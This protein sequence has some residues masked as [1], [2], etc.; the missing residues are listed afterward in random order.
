MTGSKGSTN[1]FLRKNKPWSLLYAVIMCDCAAFGSRGALGALGT[2]GPL[3]FL[4]LRFLPVSA[5]QNS[6]CNS[7]SSEKYIPSSF[8][9]LISP[10][11]AFESITAS[12]TVNVDVFLNNSFNCSSSNPS[13]SSPLVPTA[14][15]PAPFVA[16]SLFSLSPSS[17]T[18]A[19]V[20][21]RIRSISSNFFIIISGVS[22]SC[23]YPT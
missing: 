18:C 4:P 15:P 19:L 16:P 10:K 12:F 21:C 11:S 6:S 3:D 7:S 8:A 14:S 13:C 20:A 17:P 23:T 1:F 5:S 2:L 22:S 9:I